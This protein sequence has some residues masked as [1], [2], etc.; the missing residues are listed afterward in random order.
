[1]NVWHRFRL[2]RP[3]RGVTLIEIL[4]VIAIILTLMGLLLA[5][6]AGVRHR[7]KMRATRLLLDG[8]SAALYMYHQEF[9]EYPDSYGAP[10][11]AVDLA[12]E[13]ENTEDDGTLF[14]QLNGKDG[15]GSIKSPGTAYEKRL[16]PYLPLTPENTRVEGTKTFIVDSFDPPHKIRYFNSEAF[17]RNYVAKNGGTDAAKKDAL[18]KVHNPNFELYSLGANGVAEP[19][20]HNLVDDGGDTRIDDRGEYDGRDEDNDLTNWD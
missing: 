2:A 9:D 10:T 6:V 4:I 12:S 17:I 16:S 20:R 19:V 1:V 18:K 14:E 8:L 3:T 7:A 5:A 15:K 11:Y 13:Y